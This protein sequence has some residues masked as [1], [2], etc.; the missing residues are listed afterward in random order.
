MD[1]SRFRDYVAAPLADIFMLRLKWITCQRTRKTWKKIQV[2]WHMGFHS[3]LSNQKSTNKEN[4][5]FL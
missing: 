2:I 5:K 4:I 1:A 3:R